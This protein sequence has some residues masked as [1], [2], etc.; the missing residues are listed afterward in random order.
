MQTFTVCVTSVWI[1]NCVSVMT[2]MLRF[3]KF[4]ISRHCQQAWTTSRVSARL[5]VI[6]WLC[7]L[8]GPS[9]P[10]VAFNI[11]S[12]I[13][14]FKLITTKSLD[15]LTHGCSLI[16]YNWCVD[17]LQLVC[18]AGYCLNVSFKGN[19]SSVSHLTHHYLTVDQ[20]ALSARCRLRLVRQSWVRPRLRRWMSTQTDGRRQAG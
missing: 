7:T 12:N 4:T 8:W 14:L 10:S 17:T 5:S 6:G 3:Y 19:G 9:Q 1:E 16:L 11:E 18:I 2:E 13:Q 15:R 20:A